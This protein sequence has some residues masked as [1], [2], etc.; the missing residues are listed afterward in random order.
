MAASL[1]DESSDNILLALLIF[2]INAP[3]PFPLF[4][5]VGILSAFVVAFVSTIV[6]VS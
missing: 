6:I 5:A 2:V 3:L 1:F 4:G